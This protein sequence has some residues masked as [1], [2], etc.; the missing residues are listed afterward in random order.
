VHSIE[1]SW[2]PKNFLI[3]ISNSNRRSRREERMVICGARVPKPHPRLR[4]VHP[5]I[6]K[7][8][9]SQGRGKLHEVK[10]LSPPYS[11]GLQASSQLTLHFPLVTFSQDAHKK[12]HRILSFFI[13]TSFGISS[14]VMK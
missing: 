12:A 13:R 8:S 6:P 11:L 5:L 9:Q 2:F 4:V 10:I 7:P 3:S 14:A 1:P